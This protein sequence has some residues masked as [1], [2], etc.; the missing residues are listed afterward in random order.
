M[1]IQVNTDHNIDGST[2]FVT[3]VDEVIKD[4]FSRFSDRLT[5][6]QVHF[7]DQNGPKE[8]NMAT[9]CLMEVRIA[10]CKSTAV[11]SNGNSTD[12]ALEG[13]VEKMK[14]SI[15]HTLGHQN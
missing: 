10:G 8:G 4:A 11:S 12:E 6:V 15:E 1:N 9:R 13:A 14:H 7:S 3:Y 2:K 5:H